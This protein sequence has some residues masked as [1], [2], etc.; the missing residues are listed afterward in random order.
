MSRSGPRQI[1]D[2]DPGNGDGHCRRLVGTLR[3]AR[4]FDPALMPL[5]QWFSRSAHA[6]P[7]KPQGDSSP[8][9]D[10]SRPGEIGDQ[11]TR[12][13]SGAKQVPTRDPLREI[14][15]RNK[16]R[17]LRDAWAD[18][19]GS[20]SIRG[21]KTH[22][23]FRTGSR[24]P[25]GQTT[26]DSGARRCAPCRVLPLASSVEKSSHPST[27]NGAF[28][29][30]AGTA[31]VAVQTNR[32]H[33]LMPLSPETRSAWRATNGFPRRGLTPA[34]SAFPTPSPDCPPASHG[35]RRIVLS[36]AVPARPAAGTGKPSRDALA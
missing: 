26:D 11:S 31:S 28:R 6:R 33:A 21:S 18:P 5:L 13:A 4:G 15:R 10:R 17:N 3:S 20:P 24:G 35:W 1:P 23:Q 25:P 8:S 12:T 19:N 14:R 32:L 27:C 2:P 7:H 30:E 34:R 36:L 9:S 29:L 16:D 22:G